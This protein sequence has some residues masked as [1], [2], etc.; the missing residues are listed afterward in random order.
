VKKRAKSAL[1]A[2]FNAW[3]KQRVE[4]AKLTLTSRVWAKLMSDYELTTGKDAPFR[5]RHA[6]RKKRKGRKAK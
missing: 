2:F 5:P 1:D 3:V 4:G 6:A